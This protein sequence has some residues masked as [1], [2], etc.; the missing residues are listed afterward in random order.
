MTKELTKFGPVYIG[1]IGKII[2]QYQDGSP[3]LR[4][5]W[6]LLYHMIDDD[7][8]VNFYEISREAIDEVRK[9]MTGNRFN[10]GEWIS[11]ML[12]LEDDEV[13]KKVEVVQN[14]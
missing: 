5:K 6:V 1:H 3:Q 14:G 11:A 4:D 12:H 8:P 7:Y 2:N 13:I 10:S 9:I